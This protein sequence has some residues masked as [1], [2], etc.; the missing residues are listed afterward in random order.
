MKKKLIH[1][2][3]GTE[4]TIERTE[5]GNIVYLNG[6]EMERYSDREVLAY[7]FQGVWLIV[8]D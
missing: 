5:K 8:E 1:T 3:T 4:Y 7:I 6:E 2:L